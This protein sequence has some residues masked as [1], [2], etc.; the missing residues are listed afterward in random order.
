MDPKLISEVNEYVVNIFNHILSIEERALA[1][2]QFSDLTVNEM[3]VIEAISLQGAS[4]SS[5]IADKLKITMGTLSV[6]IQNLVKKG[7]VERRRGE[8]DRRIVQLHLTKKGR[9]LYRLHRKFHM[10]MIQDTLAGMNPD[11]VDAV[12]KGL[13]NLD[14]FLIGKAQE[15]EVSE[16]DLHE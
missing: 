11:E 2:S 10:L 6:S 8:P 13:R 12:I 9:L 1:Q 15:F 14:G 5:D 3:H 7:Y 4:R 16:E